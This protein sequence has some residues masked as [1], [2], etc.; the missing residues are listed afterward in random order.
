MR[1]KVILIWLLASLVSLVSS[2]Q[3]VYVPTSKGDIEALQRAVVLGNKTSGKSMLALYGA[4][5]TTSLV[6]DG[7][8]A[9]TI[10]PRASTI[11]YV[12]KPTS[13]PIQAFK[14]IQLKEKKKNR[15]LPYMKTGAYSGSKT[16]LDDIQLVT[17]KITDELYS[18]R[19]V[20]DM[21]S[22]EYA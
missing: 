19:P 5:L 8:H 6:L 2:A 9:N 20:G 16:D 12:F 22:G 21:R 11:F 10:L 1:Q 14:L 18:L 4:K 7:K 13:V 17:E 3:E 15:E